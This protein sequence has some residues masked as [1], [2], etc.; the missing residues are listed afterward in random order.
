MQRWHHE[1]H[2]ARRN[3]RDL[4]RL[5][6][7]GF[8][9]PL[10]R[11]RQLGRFRKRNGLDCGKAKCFIC[12]GDKLLDRQTRTERLADLKMKEGMDELYGR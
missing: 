11:S 4:A 5:L 10:D 2:I 3:Y 9:Q 8:D 7:S 1:R 12:H 6:N